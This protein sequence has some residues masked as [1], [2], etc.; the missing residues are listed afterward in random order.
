MPST[1][2]ALVAVAVIAPWPYRAIARS[3]APA[4]NGLR[5]VVIAG[6]DAV[7]VIQQKTAVAPIVEVR[8]RNDQPVAGVLVRFA[9]RG[10]RG[11]TLDGQAT[12][13]ITTD[14]A[15]R[16]AVTN[17]TPTAPGTLQIDV[18]ASAGGQ[19]ATTTITQRTVATQAEAEQARQGSNGS[20]SAAAGA[21]AGGAGGRSVGLWL[22]GAAAAGGG[23]FAA[24]QLGGDDGG[25]SSPGSTGSTGSSTTPPPPPTSTSRSVT[26]NGTFALPFRGTFISG[27][28]TCAWN[29][30]I[31]GTVRLVLQVAS[32]GTVT[33]QMTFPSA[34]IP[35]ISAICG[36]GVAI[37]APGGPAPFTTMNAPVTGS[38]TAMTATDTSTTS[39]T[40]NGPGGTSTETHRWT[41]TFAGALNGNVVSG[42]LR[43][44]DAC[45]V[46]GGTCSG[47]GETTIT[48]Q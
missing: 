27:P 39:T 2:A 41:A 15:G 36:Q 1:V 35:A 3:Q 44:V 18:S 12:A 23:V 45:S 30:T 9:V 42:R 43:L 22:L 28:A 21:A 11:A 25:P 14:A 10:G 16:A 46:T 13:T 31:T 26:V 5:I 17:F 24:T 48:L 47:E 19:T 20:A 29:P 38:S 8:D 34:T 40:I 6:E 7:N 33:G 37:P 32:S 4:P